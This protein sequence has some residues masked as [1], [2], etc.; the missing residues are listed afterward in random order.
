MGFHS[1]FISLIL[2]MNVEDILTSEPIHVIC[3]TK[4]ICAVSETDVKLMC[5]YTN[6]SIKMGFWF[7]QKQSQKWREKNE[8]EDLTLDSDYLGRVKQRITTRQSDLTIRDVSEGDSGE[9]QLMFIMNDGT[10]QISLVTVNLTVTDNDRKDDVESSEKRMR[11]Q[12]TIAML[13]MLLILAVIGVLTYRFL[14]RRKRNSSQRDN[15]EVQP[16][17]TTSGN[18]A[19]QSTV[20]DFTHQPDSEEQNL[21]YSSVSFKQ[22]NKSTS[23]AHTVVYS[24]AED[25]HYATVK[26][27]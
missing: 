14:R 7:S 10:K 5:S 16:R 22:S 4:N 26:V 12:I 27:K 13:S 15:T 20:S 6:I 11:T 3:E 17:P 2:L 18:A 25:V 24:S 9:Y 23:S 21:H 1:A 8:P 19:P